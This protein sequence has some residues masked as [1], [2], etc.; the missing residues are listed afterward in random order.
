MDRLVALYDGGVEPVDSRRNHALWITG[1]DWFH[2]G[3]CA[4][5]RDGSGIAARVFEDRNG[6]GCIRLG[7]MAEESVPKPSSKQGP[8][9]SGTFPTWGPP[10]VRRF[11]VGQEDKGFLE[12]EAPGTAG[13]LRLQS[14]VR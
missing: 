13:R 10:Q 9:V 3:V 5:G 12:P 2:R 8:N 7:E 11:A 1:C 4:G 14:Y 6:S